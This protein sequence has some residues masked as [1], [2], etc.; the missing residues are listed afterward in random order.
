V[1]DLVPDID[2]R[3]IALERQLDDLDRAVDA[4]AEAARG[5]DQELERKGRLAGDFVAERVRSSSGL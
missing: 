5:G 1:D 2:R 3:A 4:G